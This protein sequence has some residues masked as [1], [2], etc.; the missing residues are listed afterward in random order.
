[1]QGFKVFFI[2]GIG[3][4]FASLVCGVAYNNWVGVEVTEG[5]V[6]FWSIPLVTSIFSFGILIFTVKH[7]G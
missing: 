1:M 4:S 7:R 6:Y 3:Y 5:W 2:N